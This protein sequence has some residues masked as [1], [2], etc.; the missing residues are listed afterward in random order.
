MLRN[1]KPQ[2][3]Y[4][5]EQYLLHREMTDIRS[6]P[7]HYITPPSPV[8]S[9]FSLGDESYA[10]CCREIYERSSF[11][12]QLNYSEKRA[13]RPSI[14]ISLLLIRSDG[15]PRRVSP[16]HGLCGGDPASL[17]PFP[18]DAI[19]DSPNAKFPSPPTSRDRGALFDGGSFRVR[20]SWRQQIEKCF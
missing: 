18:P 3:Q 19:V 17:H 14:L 2:D 20:A 8:C 7:V 13:L 12:E 9:R 10:G 6:S 4:E 1:H 15:H 16:A 11:R 5:E